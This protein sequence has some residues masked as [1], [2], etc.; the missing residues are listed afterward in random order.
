MEKILRQV[1]DSSLSIVDGVE[2]IIHTSEER[3]ETTVA[4]VRKNAL[5]RF[6]TLF[7][8]AVTF[9]VSTIFYGIDQIIATTPLLA[10]HPVISI[11]IGVLVLIATG[12]LY[13]KLG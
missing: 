11:F 9:G 10:G 5:K 13:K 4:P 1:A 8:L 7:L 2:K 3:L 12:H 6:P